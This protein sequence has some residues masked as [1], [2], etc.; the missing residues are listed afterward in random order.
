MTIILDDDSA[1]DSEEP[2]DPQILKRS[3]LS[4]ADRVEMGWESPED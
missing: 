2:I 1:P 3:K 4:V